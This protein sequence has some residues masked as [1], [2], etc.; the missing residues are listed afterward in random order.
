MIVPAHVT[1]NSECFS[2]ILVPQVRCSRRR[3]LR[4]V[5]DPSPLECTSVG[6]CADR[7]VIKRTND[8]RNRTRTES[9]TLQPACRSRPCRLPA[10]SEA[11][12]VVFFTNGDAG[13]SDA[14]GS[15]SPGRYRL[16]VS[17]PQYKSQQ[18]RAAGIP[19]AGRLELNFRLLPLYDVWEAGQYRSWLLP[20]SQQVLG[21]HG[22]DVD[23]IRVAVF[24]AD[25][26]LIL[27]LSV[28]H[29]ETFR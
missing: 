7:R 6:L 18:A 10:P 28:N 27:P 25:R 15:L 17:A 20:K 2:R 5:T 8:P 21:Y 12:A 24:N 16:T 26:G 29:I 14:I 11:T 3:E 4:Y 13:G 1:K 23:T 9:W 22:P 19:V